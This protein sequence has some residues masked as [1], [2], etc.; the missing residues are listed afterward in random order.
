MARTYAAVLAL[1]GLLVVLVR[2]IKDGAGCDGTIALGLA[3]MATLGAIGLVVGLIAQ[4]TI[5]ESVRS[6]IEAE[7]AAFSAQN[8]QQE[9]TST[10][11]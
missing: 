9:Q 1:V 7:L 10:P 11:S 6:Q 5:D 4:Q 2:A 8:E 3:W